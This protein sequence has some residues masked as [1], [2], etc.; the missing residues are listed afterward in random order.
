RDTLLKALVDVQN[1][2]MEL[3]NMQ[4]ILEDVDVNW[5][6][7][8]PSV[9]WDNAYQKYKRSLQDLDKELVVAGEA[10]ELSVLR[11]KTFVQGQVYL[12]IV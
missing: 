7:K 12:K 9:E 4:D 3:I 2:A 11:F 10:Y 5:M 1:S 8:P 6:G